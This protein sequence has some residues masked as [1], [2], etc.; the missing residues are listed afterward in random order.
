M[1]ST[2]VVFLLGL[3]LLTFSGAIIYKTIKNIELIEVQV[4]KTNKLS[5]KRLQR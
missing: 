2:K 5:K 1:T 3:M 4:K